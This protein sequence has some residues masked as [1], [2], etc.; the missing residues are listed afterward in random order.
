MPRFFTYFF[1]FFFP[2]FALSAETWIIAI[3][4]GHGGK[5]PGAIGKRLHLY[6]KTVTYS[7]AKELKTLLDKD[8]RF[9]AVLTRNGDYFIPVPQRSDIARRAKADF[10]ISIHADSARN[11]QAKGAS[12]WVLS[13]RRADNEMG[14]WLEDHEKRS[15]LLGGAGDVLA[16]H[17]EKYLNKTVLDL[18]FRHSQRVGYELGQIVLSNFKKITP[19][20]RTTPQHASLGV[21]RSPDI[22]S[23]L[24]ETGFLSNR[25]EERQLN[26]LQYRKKL[27]LMIYQSL[28]TY[29][30]QQVA[31]QSSLQQHNAINFLKDSGKRHKVKAK[32][33]LS[34]IARQYRISVKDLQ[35]F[36]HLNHTTLSIGQVLK[37]PVLRTKNILAHP[38][39]VKGNRA[40]PFSVLDLKQ[41]KISHYTVQKGDT[42]SAIARRFDTPITTLKKLN[43]Q[44]RDGQIFVGQRLRLK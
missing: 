10:L 13:T 2:L 9:K 30:N 26:S 38:Q 24:V 11:L 32:E 34:S 42:L 18:Q 41:P 40:D 16:S 19:L 44:S 15:E 3:D 43:P 23:I 17:N 27:A 12:V 33:T 22:P 14:R 37:I 5:D 29:Y 1:L 39:I 20:S 35:R 8:R 28:V 7:I 31:I 4:P 36:N 21:L 25:T 6:E